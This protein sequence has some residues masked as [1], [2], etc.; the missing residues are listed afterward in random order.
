MNILPP[1]EFGRVGIMRRKRPVL[2]CSK[3]NCWTE[4]VTSGHASCATLIRPTNDWTS[5]LE[6]QDPHQLCT[7]D[8]A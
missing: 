2:K 3:H 4:Q 8:N 1:D 7:T 5:G 6:A